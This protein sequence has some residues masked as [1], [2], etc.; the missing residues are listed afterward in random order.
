MFCRILLVVAVAA[1]C[2]P[3]EPY[4]VHK[5]GP[6]FE[7]WFTRITDPESNQSVAVILASYQKKGSSD[8]SS[9]WAAAIVS[10]ANGSVYTEQVFPEQATVQI[11]DRGSPISN[12]FPEK[13]PAVFEVSSEFGTLAVNDTRAQLR[14]VF[15]SGLRITASLSA[16][17]PWDAGFPETRGPEG[18]AGKLPSALLP[19]HYFV[20][21]VA[22][23]ATYSLNGVEGAG[24]AHQEANYGGF[25]PDAWT[26]VQG[27]TPD[28]KTQL[29]LT[30]GAFTIAGVTTRQF[31]LAYRSRSFQW[32][33]RSI[34]VDRISASVDACQNKLQ[35]TAK[36]PLG[37]RHLELTVSAPADTFSDPLFFPTPNG[38]SNDPGSVESY[39]ATASITLFDRSGN[40]L[41]TVSIPQTAL[42]FGGAYR[43]IND[44]ATISV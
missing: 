22:S 3:F 6:W 27:M 35:L 14:F 26:W 10:Y 28:G 44:G 24:F 18:W 23:Q 7:G 36:T 29:V 19:T 1:V 16:R 20:Q 42:E 33:F 25:F 4:P 30:G 21:T 38:W 32:N 43:C 5:D 13:Q 40:Q 34:D 15:P 11:T 8:F 31:I 12:K 9:S 39:M 17:V 41:E 2:S 37:H